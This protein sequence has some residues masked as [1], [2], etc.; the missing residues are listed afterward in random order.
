MDR[1]ARGPKLKCCP[2]KGGS[3][4]SLCSRQ[5]RYY[6]SPAGQKALKLEEDRNGEA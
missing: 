2:P 5:E 1:E 6:R 4:E 3:R